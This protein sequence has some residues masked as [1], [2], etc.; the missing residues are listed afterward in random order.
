M[1]LNHLDVY[2]YLDA[3]QNKD[4]VFRWFVWT[5][6]IFTLMDEI[7]FMVWTSYPSP[8]KFLCWNLNGIERWVGQEGEA[9][10]NGTSVFV[11]ENP[12]SSAA[13]PPDENT[14][15][16]WYLWSRKLSPNTQYASLQN[17]EKQMS[18]VDKLPRLWY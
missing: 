2:Y 5:S 13:F 3:F 1:L 7:S 15:K 4:Q 16:S 11:K 14:L 17:C 9:L 18:V 8:F 12:E 10:T 6:L